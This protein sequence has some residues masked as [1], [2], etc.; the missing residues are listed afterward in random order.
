MPHHDP[1][2][3]VELKKLNDSLTLAH[4]KIDK[5]IN[6]YAHAERKIKEVNDAF[7]DG[8]DK[9]REY[10]EAVIKAKKAEESFYV[11][12]KKEVIKKGLFGVI[13]ILSGLI[14]LGVEGW[15]RKL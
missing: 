11:D 10:H 9:H 15:I 7:P 4:K 12:L 13:V 2:L 6:L 3:C 5:A 14:W 1:E 8:V